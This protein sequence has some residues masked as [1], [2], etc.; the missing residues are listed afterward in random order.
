M[1][2]TVERYKRY[3][4]VSDSLCKMCKVK[5]AID[6]ITEMR[7]YFIALRWVIA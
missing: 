1:L 6:A 5:I 7:Y 4:L 3:Y 2:S